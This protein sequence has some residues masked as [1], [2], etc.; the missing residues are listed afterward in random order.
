ML[1]LQIQNCYSMNIEAF[2]ELIRTQ[3]STNAE[4]AWQ[5]A[6][7]Q[8][9]AGDKH[10]TDFV[11]AVYSWTFGDLKGFGP[12]KFLMALHNYKLHCKIFR[13]KK[14]PP[15]SHAIAPLVRE[16]EI[17][18]LETKIFPTGF[19]SFDQAERLKFNTWFL[20]EIGDELAAMPSLKSLVFQNRYDFTI[21]P[22][23]IHCKSLESLRLKSYNVALPDNLPEMAQLREI[24]LPIADDTSPIL[25]DCHQLQSLVLADASYKKREDRFDKFGKNVLQLTNVEKLTFLY[26]YTY[27]KD[28][29][30]LPDFIY[31]MRHLKQLNFFTDSNTECAVDHRI[32]EIENLETLSLSN[33]DYSILPILAKHPSLKKL[34]L[35]RRYYYYPEELDDI[36]KVLPNI[37]VDTIAIEKW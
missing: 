35:E 18:A 20:T 4:I 33:V 3:D 8:K 19:E 36:K 30:T 17:E 9:K 26:H 10:F 6:R 23:F 24:G 22:E 12:V 1:T 29:V 16:I 31:N 21:K 34:Y 7:G 37:E 13:K 11:K 32:L 15:Q 28:R 14:V 2:Y 27:G 5:I 25:W